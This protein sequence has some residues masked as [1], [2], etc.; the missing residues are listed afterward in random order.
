MK[1]IEQVYLKNHYTLFPRV[2]LEI[3]GN[4]R[5]LRCISHPEELAVAILQ[6]NN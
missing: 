4:Q 1:T 5:D 2:I 3:E 6:R